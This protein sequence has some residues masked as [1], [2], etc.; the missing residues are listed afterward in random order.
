MQPIMQTAFAVFLAVAV[1]AGGSAYAED[2]TRGYAES[3]AMWVSQAAEAAGRAADAR[4]E[5]EAA[6]AEGNIEA[7]AAA[8]RKARAAAS[9]AATRGEKASL[10]TMDGD[11][12]AA[13]RGLLEA[14]RAAEAAEAA[15]AAAVRAFGKQAVEAAI[16]AAV[17]AER[18]EASEAAAEAGRAGPFGYNAGDEMPP[19]DGITNDG[20]PFARVPAPERFDSLA[21][22]G[23]EKAGICW[24]R[25]TK[26]I[27]N[28][29][30]SGNQI[31]GAM[32]ALERAISK[33]Y[34]KPSR[35]IDRHDGTIWE[36][37]VS[38]WSGSG[39]FMQELA[40]GKRRYMTIWNESDFSSFDSTRDISSLGIM[41]SLL[42]NPWGG[43]Y[44]IMLFAD[45][46]D[47]IPSGPLQELIGSD[48][49]ANVRVQYTLN[50]IAECRAEVDSAL[51]SDL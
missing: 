23:T 29:D 45:A 22:F 39:E 43:I 14:E 20:F 37:F 31:K 46:D 16:E 4:A 26:R 21:V 48:I 35:R 7:A 24:I 6:A 5:T 19:I 3:R 41:N 30:P 36:R 13:G 28:V 1:L 8:M 51:D 32:E 34:G 18:T 10:Y 42:H 15:E 47:E 2:G 9:L 33:K 25:A 38:F 50:N 27:E 44:R 49:A 40:A 11:T 12:E 17:A